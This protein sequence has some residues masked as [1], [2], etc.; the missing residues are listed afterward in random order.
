M[1]K[2]DEENFDPGLFEETVMCELCTR[3]IPLNKYEQHINYFCNN[4]MAECPKCFESYPNAIIN[5]HI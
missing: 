2:K 3:Q 5:D 4:K 1:Q